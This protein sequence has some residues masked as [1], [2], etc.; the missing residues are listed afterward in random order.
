MRTVGGEL[1]LDALFITDVQEYA[2]ENAQLRV[3]SQT[4]GEPTLQ[5]VLQQSNRLKANAFAARIGAGD[6]KQGGGGSLQLDV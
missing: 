3:L 2:I 4:H 5:H 6:N 1:V